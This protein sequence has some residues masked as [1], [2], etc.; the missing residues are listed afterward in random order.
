[1]V[2]TPKDVTDAELAVLRVL[3]EKGRSTTRLLADRLYPQGPASQSATVLKLLERLESK[4]CILRDRRST[5]HIFR[6]VIEREDLIERMLQTVTDSLCDGSRTP[7]IM[8]LI[9]PKRLT[10]E[11]R[12]TLRALVEKLDESDPKKKRKP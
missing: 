9:D 7:L 3:W 10:L 11:E 1:M 4:G 5:P 12:K 2:R 8:H 6:A